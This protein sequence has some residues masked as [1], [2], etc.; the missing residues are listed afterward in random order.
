[1]PAQVAGATGC[2]WDCPRGPG[3][4]RPEWGTEPSPGVCTLSAPHR[5]C[6]SEALCPTARASRLG[7]QELTAPSTALSVVAELLR[8]QPSALCPPPLLC[9][10]IPPSVCSRPSCE[11]SSRPWVVPLSLHPAPQGSGH[12]SCGVGGRASSTMGRPP[13]GCRAGAGVEAAITMTAFCV[14]SGFL[15]WISPRKSGTWP[16]TSSLTR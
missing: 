1:M 8:N 15:S 7:T 14:T 5:C 16:S 3:R 13:G 6:H 2:L 4:R 10:Q 9:T 12:K 11:H